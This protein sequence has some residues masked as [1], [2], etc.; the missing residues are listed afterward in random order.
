[1]TLAPC[2][3][4]G[5][6]ATLDHD[7]ARRGTPRQSCIVVCTQCGCCLESSDEGDD[8]G[9][10][11]NQRHSTAPQQP[12]RPWPVRGPDFNQWYTDA[13][14]FLFF[15]QQH[16]IAWCRDSRLKYLNIRVD[17]RSGAFVM[18]A[19]DG[20]EKVTPDDFIRAA[21]GQVRGQQEKR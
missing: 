10:S 20:E 2:P 21:T 3:F 8:S 12:E 7:G 6:E 16:P 4:C 15:V 14:K 9:R 13:A 17:T 5:G 1:M 19:Q 11:W 18:F